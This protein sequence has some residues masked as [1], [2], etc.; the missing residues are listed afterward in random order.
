MVRV[1]RALLLIV[2]HLLADGLELQGSSAGAGPR[3]Q[4]PAA[5]VVPVLQSR[6]DGQLGGAFF[7]HC[8]HG[9]QKGPMSLSAY[10]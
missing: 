5:P 9:D 4:G 3:L 10:R 2:R 7:P 6:Y 8:R 1:D